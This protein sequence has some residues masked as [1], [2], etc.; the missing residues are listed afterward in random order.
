LVKRT[1]LNLAKVIILIGIFFY[2]FK[3][4]GFDLSKLSKAFVRTDLLSYAF[5]FT[6]FGLLVTSE[7]WRFLLSIQGIHLGVFQ[8]IKLT[9]VGFLFSVSLPG[10]VSGDV[11]KAYYI[12]KGR[13][14]KAILIT[15]VIFDRLIGMYS[16]FFIA[17][18]TI[19]L[20]Y[21]GE[22]ISGNAGVWSTPYFRAIGVF[23]IL[24]FIFVTAACVLFMSV[25]IEKIPVLMRIINKL[26]LHETFLN[27]YRAVHSYGKKPFSVI[28]ALFISSLAQI[29]G[30]IGIWFMSAILG[31]KVFTFIDFMIILPLCYLFNSI[32]IAP[33][34][35][36]IGEVGFGKI[37]QMFGSNE[38][39][40]VAFLMHAILIFI[41]VFF[42]GLVYLLTDLSKAS[43][44]ISN[45]DKD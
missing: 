2:L 38:G 44:Y 17:A 39:A 29:P 1:L 33:A 31:V 13:D 25:S 15:S 10:S 11:I 40:E 26:P 27:I 14:Q 12:A 18:F 3:Y 32:P 4:A 28:I 9:F 34:G 42:G 36:G 35:L 21:I 8:A 37:F 24:L 43:K 19:S 22:M 7:R 41:S 20:V 6:F 45:K 23:T 16:M 5:I 30:Y